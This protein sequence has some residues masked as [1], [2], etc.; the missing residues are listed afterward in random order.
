LLVVAAVGLLAQ[1]LF[2]QVAVAAQVDL[3]LPQEHQVE[4]LRLSQL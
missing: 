2:V 3:E 1:A 4:V